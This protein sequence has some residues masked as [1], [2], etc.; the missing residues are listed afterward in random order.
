MILQIYTKGVEEPKTLELGNQPIVIGSDAAADIV[1]SHPD[2]SA[3]QAR[4][5]PKNG[6]WVI[7]DLESTVAT[8][9]NKVPVFGQKPLGDRF[10]IEIGNCR[11]VSGAGPAPSPNREETSRPIPPPQPKAESPVAPSPKPAPRRESATSPEKKAHD[12]YKTMLHRSMVKKLRLINLLDVDEETKKKSLQIIHEL[13]DEQ[14]PPAGLDRERV[15]KEV[16]DEAFGLG[17]LEEFLTD[18]TVTEVMVNRRDQI[19]VERNGKLTKTDASFTSDDKVRLVIDRIV[20]PLGRRIDESSPLVDARLKDGSRVNAVI[21]PLALKGPSITIRKFPEQSLT[22]DDLVRFGSVT[23]P[24]ADFFQLAVKHRKN[25]VISGGTGSGKTTLLN[26]IS[27]FIPSDERIVTIEDAAELRLPQE[28]VVSLESKPPSIEG[29]GGIGIRELVINSLRMRPDRIVVGECRG[30]EAL[31]MLQAMNTGHDGSLTTAHA[32]TTRDVLARLETMVLMA[33]MD[34]PVRAI[35]EQISSAVDIIIQQ[36][37]LADGSRRIIDVVEVTGM[38][39]DK[40]LLQQIFYYKQESFDSEGRVIGR[41]VATG[42]IPT[43]VQE[44]RDR[45][46][47]VALEMFRDTE[48]GG[49]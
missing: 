37:R 15:V 2:V 19:Y 3:R 5:A 38:E 11:I 33:G 29:T 26:V 1:I 47:P 39:G 27:S 36:S 46:I 32:N 48:G 4:L 8:L 22:V 34:L 24:M 6:G 18:S 16:F 17:P 25:I 14:R 13:L 40:I 41:F 20:T 7:E 43:F 35:R 45:G 21:P 23:R 30:K 28:H 9:L 12:E 10:E 49:A 42:M 31:D 44:L